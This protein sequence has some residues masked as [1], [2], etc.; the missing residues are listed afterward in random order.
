MPAMTTAPHAPTAGVGKASMQEVAEGEGK[1]KDRIKKAKDS[2]MLADAF[3][4]TVAMAEII[5]PGISVPTF[6]AK[7]PLKKTYADIK[8]L[9]QTTLDVAYRQADTRGLIDD[10]LGSRSFKDATKKASGLRSV[11]RAVGVAKKRSNSGRWELRGCANVTLIG[12]MFRP[13]FSRI[14]FKLAASTN[15]AFWRK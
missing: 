12:R 7:A 10:V 3:S 8:R 15:S 1:A 5:T 4:D 2:T 6:D 14:P 13:T 11:F 9:R